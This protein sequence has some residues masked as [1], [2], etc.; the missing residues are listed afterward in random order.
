M[1]KIIIITILLVL[2]ACRAFATCG[3]SVIESPTGV[4]T[5]YDTSYD[6]VNNAVLAAT[7]AGATNS[8]YGN[9]V[10]IPAGD[11][12]WSSANG[13]L[14]TKDIKIIG[15]GYN[16]TIIRDGFTDTPTEVNYLYFFKFVPDATARANIDSLSDT[17]TYEIS[18]IHFYGYYTTSPSVSRKYVFAHLTYNMSLPVIR[19][20]KIHNN[21]Y[22]NMYK[23][24]KYEGYVHGVVYN[25]VFYNTGAYY[26]SGTDEKA[27]ANDRMYPGTV[28]GLF[29][30]DN[31][32]ELYNT[33]TDV[34]GGNSHGRGAIIRY[35]TYTGTTN[36]G[37]VEYIDVHSN[38]IGIA[39]G[40]FVEI[41]G[42][43][44]IATLSGGDVNRAVYTR[45]GKNI[46]MYN[47]I[48]GRSGAF[49]LTEEYSDIYSPAITGACPDPDGEKQ[50]CSDSCICQKIHDSYFFNNRRTGGAL[51][52]A[53]MM[54]VT[55][56][57]NGRDYHHLNNRVFNDPPE[58]IENVEYFNHKDSFNGTAG[59]GCG[60]SEQMNAITPTTTGV[61]F[62]VPT[63][64]STMPCSSVSSSNIGKNPAV[65]IT[66]T[67]YKWN[68][69]AWV[70][71]WS[72]Y[73]YPH[74][75]RVATVPA[76]TTI[77]GGVSI[78]GGSI[79]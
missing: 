5:A 64:I 12:T 15:A 78:S 75:L 48:G 63:N 1:R 29:L 69:S 45:G 66:G 65:P 22:T 38:Q 20:V 79:Q 25:N 32:F 11:S 59:V 35:N 23:G 4:F 46:Y 49:A 8:G 42:N 21:K 19:R 55:G 68:G 3:G 30:E 57:V 18:G 34:A 61:G 17:N 37:V 40:Q 58:I 33:E 41:Y 27:F 62:W 76:P 77:S 39:G 53:S 51:V 44:F 16:S 72:P 47:V 31:T 24:D 70:A 71:F 60:T 9:T 26:G 56:S 73:T 36:T 43:N 2:I 74:P 28:N 7:A 10:K 6:C 13:I 50:V 67:L 52:N 54:S 14:I